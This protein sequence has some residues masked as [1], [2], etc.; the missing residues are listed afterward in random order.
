MNWGA[1][2]YGEASG[3]NH[4]YQ[5]PNRPDAFRQSAVHHFY[6]R[7]GNEDIMRKLGTPMTGETIANSLQNSGKWGTGQMNEGIQDDH[8]KWGGK[9]KR[10]RNRKSRRNS[11][12]K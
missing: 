6:G 9:S 4:G 1:N 7:T 5:G 12:K 3:V 8:F 10:K 11:R 2:Q